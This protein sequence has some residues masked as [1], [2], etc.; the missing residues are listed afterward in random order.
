MNSMIN[1]SMKR[2]GSTNGGEY[3]GPCPQ[4]GG[5]DRFRVW[6]DHPDSDTGRFWCRQ[7]EWS[8]DGIQYE[9][10]INGLSFP[11]ACEELGA[12]H[13]LDKP[14]KRRPRRRGQRE[15]PPPKPRKVHTPPGD[16]WQERA[17][18]LAIECYDRLYTSEGG[19]ALAY[20]R[21][22]GLSDSIIYWACLGYHPADTYEPPGLWGL[23]RDND[24]W[25][26]RGI[27]IPWQVSD[28]NDWL[29][30]KLKVRRAQDD[31]KYMQLPGGGRGLYL[32]QTIR[33]G[34]VL[35]LCEGE[36]DA[37]SVLQG[38]RVPAVATGGATGGQLTPWRARIALAS[39][40]LVAF[41]ADDA[42]DEKA[43]W[44]LEHIP[45]AVRLRP[46]RHDVNEMLT[47]GDDL[48]AWIDGVQDATR[49]EAVHA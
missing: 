10:D 40:V 29:L 46:T 49:P 30:W 16:V 48:A 12:T 21:S 37:L 11:E 14:T 28:P 42:G 3:A 39:R 15:T 20:L 2:V 4:C 19:K 32:D 36:L 44:W 41:D 22:R 24:V 43:S 6:P 5:T 25:L 34:R 18:E 8:G 45:H 26:P 1:S 7:C 23:E 13:K 33:P 31:P 38:A 47:R 9:R 17:V 27:T 35:V